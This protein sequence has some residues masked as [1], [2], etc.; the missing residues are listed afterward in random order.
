M[1]LLA[2]TQIP[3]PADEQAFER[4]SIVLWRGLLGDPNVQRNG[5]RGQRQNGVDLF[6]VRNGDPA[7][8]VG[9]QCKLKSDGHALTA[10]EVRDEV[11]KALTF[12]PD[13]REYFIITT[14]PDDVALQELVRE[15]ALEQKAKGRAILIYVWGWN[16]LEERISENAEARKQFDP[17]YGAF[18]ERILEEVGKVVVVQEETKATFETGLSRLDARFARLES[19]HLAP[20]DSTSGTSALEAQLDAEISEYRD[21]ANAGKPR[22]ALPLLERLLARV[23]HT[24]S[25]RIKFRIK[26]NIG[27]CV[28]AL[29]DDEKAA[30][31]LSDAYDHA[32]TEPK[33]VANKAFSLLL[34]GRW[35]E[36]LAF[37]QSALDADPT[38][39]GVAGYLVQAARFDPSIGDPIDLIPPQL[40]GTAAVAVGRV[41]ALRHRGMMPA[42]WEAARQALAAHPDDRHARLF[43]A[44]ADLDE[45]LRDEKVQR[46]H[47]LT[48]EQR[49]R[50]T[51]AT[52]ILRGEWDRA[53]SS[54]GAVRPEDAAVCS[55]LVVA[56]IALDDLPAAL[57]A[58]RQ[59]LAAAPQDVE[60][61]KRAA[62]AAV[63]GNDDDLTRDLLGRLPA[64]PDATILG[65]RYHAAR[66]H[67]SEVARIGRDQSDSIPDVE[68]RLVV[69]ACRLAELKIQRPADL[70][71]EI[72]AIAEEAAD[73]ARASIV[74]ADFA[75]MEDLEAVAE[76]AFRSALQLISKDS[77]ISARLMVAMHAVRR[78]DADI[79]AD[80]LDGHVAED[81]DN[82]ALR[83]LAR[84]FVNDSPIRQ[85]A[86]RFFERLPPTIKSLEFYLHAE[87]LLHYNRG[88][89]K[90]AERC[91]RQAIELST[92]L[93]NY[94]TL[95]STLRRQDRRGEI[96]PLLKAIDLSSVKGTAGQKMY[97]AQAMFAEGLHKPALEFAYDVLQLA[98]N[99]A[100]AAL[101]YFGLMMLDLNGRETPRPTIVGLDAWVRLIGAHGESTDFVIADG[102]DRPADGVVSPKHQ[103]AAAAMGLKVGEDFTIKAA[104]GTDAVWCVAEIKHKYLHAL[105][106]V[107]GNFQTRFPDAKGFY[108][109]KMKEGDVQPALNE[110]KRVSESNRKLADLYLLQHLPMGMVATRLGGDAISFADY[111]RSLDH[112]IDTCVGTAQERDAA[113]EVIAQHR[114][115]GVVLDTYTAW[116]V[117]TI[118]AFDVLLAVFG[119][120]VIPR[121]CIDELRALRDNNE[122]GG[123]GRS[124]TIAWHDGQFIRQEHSHEETETRR[125]FISAQIDKIEKHCETVPGAAPD[126]RSELAS[127]L[128]ETFGTDVLDEAYAALEGYVL[129]S[130]DMYYRQAAT[131][132]LGSG[133]KTIWLQPIF[134]FARKAD[135]I[136]AKRQAEITVKLAW[137]RHGHLSLDAETLLS[138]LQADTSADLA[139]YRTTSAFIGTRNADLMSHLSVS[140]AVLRRIWANGGAAEMKT[141]RATGILLE[142]L[143]RFRNSDWALVLALVED[144]SSGDLREYISQ[145]VTGHFLGL[146]NLRR[147]ERE[148]VAMRAAN[149]SQARPQRRARGQTKPAP[150]PERQ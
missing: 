1:S 30:Q 45:I 21:L 10:D 112:D 51:A 23:D 52:G 11:R 141:L 64:G 88:A 91:L 69:T 8:H 37:G 24:A 47:L 41:D 104:F 48:L 94:L 20:G 140:L 145:W 138:V 67:W 81:H 13:L 57:E 31:L 123:Q 136:D 12:R 101:R 44:D 65:F 9:I 147:A 63:E 99:D 85:R 14:S 116:T 49:A 55:N 78:G 110:I 137:R 75:Q 90:D 46:G 126:T 72:T 149:Q 143:T 22:T 16:T 92:D 106:D 38:N 125:G 71:A 62:L 4:A 35:Q 98:K 100:E 131:A 108:T 60:L 128:T 79:V 150:G 118:D 66:G 122:F 96:T 80:L 19:I 15:L 124:M 7:H 28:L 83:S 105:H 25:G 74:V 43:A 73:D 115:A 144:Q 53:R 89:L 34:Q 134:A 40:R 5:R 113:Q 93:T 119:K 18:S 127:M 32:P 77:H 142:R 42:W 95:F 70:E 58:A 129:V 36:M 17:D 86:I 139:D 109:L 6:G 135:L 132:A 50:V 107:M 97:L 27:S 121:S 84:A 114:A 54:E 148:L 117:A 133:V 120:I 103:L 2:A 68:R 29:G 111:V 87:G 3:K 61:A 146:D 76:T 82:D 130:E 26:A 33:A 59:G 39:E 56:Y 102:P